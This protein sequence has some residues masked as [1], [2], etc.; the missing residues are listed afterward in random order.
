M[1]EIYVICKN[2][3][4]IIFQEFSQNFYCILKTEFR[5]Y[6]LLPLGTLL[7]LYHTVKRRSRQTLNLV[8]IGPNN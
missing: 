2:G 3:F 6:V 1:L 8:I 5:Y 4:T 7:S